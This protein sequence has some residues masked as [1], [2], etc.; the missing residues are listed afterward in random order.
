MKSQIQSTEKKDLIYSNQQTIFGQREIIGFGSAE[1]YIK[2]IDRNIAIEIIVKNHYSK[3]VFN[4]SYIHLG[5][6][7]NEELLGVLQFGHLLNNLS[8][9]ALI[10]GTKPG[11]ALE[12]NR[13]WFDDKAKRN[14]E[15]RALSYCIRYIRSKFRNI[16]WI[17]SFA[18][19]RCGRFGVVYQA[20]NFSYYGE[21]TSDFYEINGEFYHQIM[22][23]NNGR[24]ASNSVKAKKL[25]AVKHEA[26][27]HT[28]RQFRYI[29]FMN[30]KTKKKCKLMEM[31]YPKHY[32]DITFPTSGS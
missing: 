24:S 19:Q 20:S 15:S 12:L 7:I 22:L 9:G 28:L 27:K 3:K 26:I 21:H 30:A 32:N 2:E 31:P 5:C 17:Q 4:N 18:D 29:Y 13:M 1:F 23:T 16:Q 8:V 25:K 14:S 10:E 11:E 6:F